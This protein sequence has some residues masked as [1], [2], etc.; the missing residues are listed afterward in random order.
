[1]MIHFDR[2]AEKL[3]GRSISVDGILQI[4]CTKK[5]VLLE[6]LHKRKTVLQRA[7][8]EEIIIFTIGKQSLNRIVQSGCVRAQQ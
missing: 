1:M 4:P 3:P 5:K 7:Y 8:I 6:C 2:C